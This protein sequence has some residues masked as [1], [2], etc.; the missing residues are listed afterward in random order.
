MLLFHMTDMDDCVHPRAKEEFAE[1][2]YCI[3]AHKTLVTKGVTSI[4]INM[5]SKEHDDFISTL[6]TVIL[7]H[8][9]ERIKTPNN[10][11]DVLMEHVGHD[12]VQYL[13]VIYD[14]LLCSNQA[15]LTHWLRSYI[16]GIN[17][18]RWFI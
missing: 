9:A 10:I 1:C 12:T 11:E 5:S 16:H 2:N 14:T 4:V 7:S 18:N 6:K 17:V 8:I 13:E 15:D 3:N